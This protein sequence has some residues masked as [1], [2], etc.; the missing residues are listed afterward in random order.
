MASA[1]T[2][3]NHA[4]H[5]AEC[6][7]DDGERGAET[8]L[9]FLLDPTV[10]PGEVNVGVRHTFE[11]DVTSGGVNPCQGRLLPQLQSNG[12]VNIGA[13]T[14]VFVRKARSARARLLKLSCKELPEA[15]IGWH[16]MSP[17][18]FEADM[19]RVDDQNFFTLSQK[20]WTAWG[21]LP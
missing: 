14:S 20:L 21:R 13:D 10:N 4:T 7:F 17:S 18:E 6:L 16:L 5:N 11:H 2:N 3:E 1:H 9:S 19:N 15:T 12:L 8:R